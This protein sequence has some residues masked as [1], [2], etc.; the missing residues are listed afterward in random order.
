ML[1]GLSSFSFQSQKCSPGPNEL[2]TS[3]QNLFGKPSTELRTE[4]LEAGHV[5]IKPESHVHRLNSLF[6][7][8]GAAIKGHVSAA[9]F[10]LGAV[11]STG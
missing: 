11:H 7:P 5:H 1:N 4:A 10:S 9:E 8:S 6:N 3:S 2:T